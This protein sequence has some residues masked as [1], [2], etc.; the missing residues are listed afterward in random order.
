MTEDISKLL[1]TPAAQG[2]VLV[3][4]HF[5][6]KAQEQRMDTLFT[7][8]GLPI[9]KKKK[10]HAALLLTLAATLTLAPGCSYVTVKREGFS[11]VMPA[12]PWQDSTRALERLNISSK[13]NSFTAS[14][15]GLNDS[16]N[17]STNTADLFKKGI[18]GAVQGA[19]SALK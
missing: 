13:T 5:R 12:W 14:V 3:W 18:E 16:E 8:F 9:P 1:T 11:A 4:L 19:V 6:L 2:A 15:R 10:L 7:H 17:T